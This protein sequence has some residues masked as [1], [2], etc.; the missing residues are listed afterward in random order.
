MKQVTEH[1]K[2]NIDEIPPELSKRA[3]ELGLNLGNMAKKSLQTVVEEDNVVASG[4]LKKSFSF[5]ADVITPDKFDILV[6]TSASY[7]KA[8]DEGSRPHFTPPSELIKW[9]QQKGNRGFPVPDSESGIKKLAWAIA[10]KHSR[11]GIKARNITSK[12]VALID[13]DK[14]AIIKKWTKK[15]LKPMK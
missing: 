8:V 12:A 11:E 2:S 15:W 10:V 13:N 5:S 7:F 14:D 3:R 6:K 1:I 9:I 4:N